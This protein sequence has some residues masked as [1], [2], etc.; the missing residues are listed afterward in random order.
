MGKPE[1][2][3]FDMDG[4]LIDSEPI[5][6]EIEKKLFNNLGIDV[7]ENVH[8]SFMGASNEFMY[9]DLRSR[10]GLPESVSELME[11]DELFRT[12]YFNRLDTIPLNDGLI[13]LLDELKSAGIKL[14]VATSSSP[15]IANIL[16]SRCGINH[17]FDA[18]VA[19]SEA[20]KSKPSP[21]VYLLAAKKIGVSPA[22]CI[23][24]EDS[25]NGL[26]AAKNAGMYCIVIQSDKEII[27]KLSGAD[28][29][30]Q[31]F[32]EITSL[33]LTEIFSVKP[34]VD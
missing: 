14:A 10:F 29:L 19:T 25:P 2:V 32:R 22:D 7:S 23:V 31:S 17:Y 5:H 18:I 6:I 15:D 13:S 30:I 26:S 28:Y 8:R 4:V 33:K 1:A 3:I 9:A 12:D 24:F 20:G 34:I 27:Q 11:R 16:L 21:E